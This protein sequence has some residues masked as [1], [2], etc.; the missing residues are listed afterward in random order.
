MESTSGQ[1][2]ARLR[3]A[4]ERLDAKDLAA[5]IAIYEE[6]LGAAGER[7]DVLVTIS[8]D[9]GSTG[10]V[11]EVIEVI[12]PRYDVRRH[13]PATGFNLLQAY[14]AARDAEAAQHI[15]DLLFE[16]KRPELEERLYGFSN[17]VAE[18]LLAEAG[19]I[20]APPVESQIEAAPGEAKMGLVSISKPIWF[21]GLEPIASDFLPAKDGRLRRIAFAHLALPGARGEAAEDL[22]RP[23]NE[24][25]LLSCALPA[26]F[27]EVFFFARAY[28]PC[29]A[30][31]FEERSDGGR[32]PIV[33]GSEWNPAHLRQLVDNTAG[34]LD[35]IVTGALRQSAGDYELTLRLWEVKK[36]RER[37]RFAALWTPASVDAELEKLRTSI[38]QFMEWTP[39]PDGTGLGYAFPIAPRA[40]VEALGASAQL[41]LAE[42][43]I[44]PKDSVGPL[45]EA[46]SV[47]AQ[48]APQSTTA[49]LAW[50]TMRRRAQA[51]GLPLSADA[52]VALAETPAVKAALAALPAQPNG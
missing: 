21:Y 47:F 10:H 31:A 6:V 17:A 35:Y 28:L 23:G 2:L 15:L 40:W 36:F 19:G 43:G 1:V 20:G 50:L 46:Q 41:F 33:F 34:G 7:A 39:Y 12:G 11:A 44:A 18:L 30:I 38:C 8:G 32:R 37:K 48:A 9:L 24:L 16:L 45:T 29:L 27:A 3:T 25:T 42:K 51:L 22:L 49:S 26:W 5:A 52:P 4:R 14:I 13:G